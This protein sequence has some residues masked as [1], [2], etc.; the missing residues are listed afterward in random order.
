MPE[1]LSLKRGAV[2]TFEGKTWVVAASMM[3]DKVLLRSV[4]DNKL[5]RDAP[6]KALAPA[7]ETRDAQGARNNV[8]TLSE[9]DWLTARERYGIIEPLLAYQGR[10]RL[11]FRH[12]EGWAK[13]HGIHYTTLYE[14]MRRFRHHGYAG[15]TRQA[16][17][18]QGA[19]RLPQAVQELLDEV[20]AEHYLSPKRKSIVEVYEILEKRYQNKGLKAPHYNTL[21]QRIA[22]LPERAKVA[23]REGAQAAAERFDPKPGSFPG[24][25]WPLAV[26]Q[27]DHVLLNIELQDG[28][29]RNVGR[30]WLTIAIDVFSR[31]IVGFYL[32]LDP[33]GFY[34]VGRCLAMAILPKD[35]LLSRYS[36]RSPWPCFG[37]MDLVLADNAKEF[38]SEAMERAC[39]NFE[40]DSDFRPV[41]KPRYGAYIESYAG[42]LKDEIGALPGAYLPRKKT[43]K[44]P[45]L[46]RRKVQGVNTLENL[47]GWLVRHVADVYHREVHSTLGTTPLK[48]YEE[49]I[50]GTEQRPGRG[51]PKVVQGERAVNV[52]FLP[53]FQAT[54]QDRGVVHQRVWYYHE[55]L[56]PYIGREGAKG[57]K[58]TFLYDPHDVTTIYFIDPDQ[59]GAEP[60]PI[61]CR[62]ASHPPISLKE[63]KAA[64][65]AV[66]DQ[67]GDPDD[68]V[69][70]FEAVED[71]RR[72][73][74]ELLEHSK[75]VR[76]A[77]QSRKSA[78]RKKPRLPKV[79]KVVE[80]EEVEADGDATEAVYEPFTDSRWG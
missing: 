35:E 4:S 23:A 70:V 25:D 7:P 62:D 69:V 28:S 26:I 11:S 58:Y 33:P 3:P 42:K 52:N 48:K 78:V 47:E 60:I 61:P 20:I 40:I 37:I 53:S 41:R 14:W 31:M 50:H 79:Q 71:L 45:M 29:G 49:G 65:K 68:E 63:L 59:P 67:G 64:Q 73:Q 18:D 46:E 57:R 80:D 27:I 74:D 54:I 24:A 16:R 21:R 72:Q 1:F 77:Q 15:L 56:N 13:K 66:R 2:V 5:Y 22:N 19:A 36:V 8:L 44:N 43:K 6:I 76:R 12:V 75:R 51:W 55:V 9:K 30:P 10:G 34:S 17:T 39:A 32:S 38:S